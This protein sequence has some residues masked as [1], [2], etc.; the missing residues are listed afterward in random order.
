MGG[1]LPQGCGGR[2]ATADFR[3]G[4]GDCGLGIERRGAGAAGAGILAGGPPAFVSFQRGERPR[5]D[6]DQGSRALVLMPLETEDAA[7]F[8]AGLAALTETGPEAAEPT[9]PRKLAMLK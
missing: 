2:K 8:L 9:W 3:F 1:S 5:Y 4:M 6:R 7:L